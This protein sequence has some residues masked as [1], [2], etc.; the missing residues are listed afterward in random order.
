MVYIEITNSVIDKG[1]EI[2]FSYYKTGISHIFLVLSSVY[3][4]IAVFH[5]A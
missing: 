4:T 2:L 5:T 1:F 3:M